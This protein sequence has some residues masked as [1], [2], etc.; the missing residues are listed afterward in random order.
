MKNY[1]LIL[2]AA[3]LSAG[4]ISAQTTAPA[5]TEALPADQ[6]ASAKD[7]AAAKETAVKKEAGVPREKFDPKRDPAADLAKAVEQAAKNGKNIILDVGGEWCG[8]CVFMDKFFVQNAGL[9]TYRDNNFVWVKVN[10]SEDNEN[11][12]FLDA[13]PQAAGYPHLYVLDKSG[14]LLHSEDTSLLEK[15]KGYDLEKFT[16]FLMAWAPKAVPSVK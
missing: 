4:S 11:K 14:K 12:A 3:V 9:A 16:G 2:A 13:Y 6:A 7:A 10:Y 15:G 1:L 8:W 5:I